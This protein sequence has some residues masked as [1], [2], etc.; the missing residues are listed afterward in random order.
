MGG[1]GAGVDGSSE[2]REDVGP[3]RPVP[4]PGCDGRPLRATTRVTLDEIYRFAI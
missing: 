2:R 3:T 4:A 1:I